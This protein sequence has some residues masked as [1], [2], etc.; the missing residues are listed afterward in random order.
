MQPSGGA[1]ADNVD[2]DLRAALPAQVFRHIG[3]PHAHGIE[4][5][6]AHDAVVGAH[7]DPLGRS[8]GDGVHDDD[9]VTQHVELDA[10]AA[11][12][13]VET[14]LHAL[15]LLGADVG[16]VGVQLFEHARNGPLDDG[17]HIHF[18]DIKPRKV[19]ENLCEF[20][21]LLRVIRILRREGQNAEN[22]E[23]DE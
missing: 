2:F 14:L 7:A 9:R 13:P 8:S 4:R 20:L 15:H 18:I 23:Y 17:F 16:R 12:L 3:A 5:V 6:D 10:Y 21:K 22:G 11:E 1:V 19:A